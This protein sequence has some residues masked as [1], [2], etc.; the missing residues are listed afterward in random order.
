MYDDI[1]TKED[2]LIFTVASCMLPHLLYNQTH[3]LFTL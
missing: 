1:S 2:V 3:A